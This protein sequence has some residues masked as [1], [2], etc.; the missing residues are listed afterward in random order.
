MLKQRPCCEKDLRM[1][2]TN[3]GCQVGGRASEE[4][5]GLGKQDSE[6]VE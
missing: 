4:A 5:A 1:M 6:K 2:L 3:G